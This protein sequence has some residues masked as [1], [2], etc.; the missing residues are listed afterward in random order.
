MYQVPPGDEIQYYEGKRKG[1]ACA[2]V[3]VH[4]SHL[5]SFG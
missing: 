2:T 1:G 5:L 4:S 3:A